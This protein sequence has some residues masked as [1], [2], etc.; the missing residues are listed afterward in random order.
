[1]A[2]SEGIGWGSTWANIQVAAQDGGTLLEQVLACGVGDIAA[3]A[4]RGA[5]VGSRRLGSE[6]VAAARWVSAD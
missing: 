4:E 5:V 3:E 2:G 6:A 1:M